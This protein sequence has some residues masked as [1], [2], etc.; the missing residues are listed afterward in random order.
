MSYLQA[1]S[2]PHISIA[3]AMPFSTFGAPNIQLPFLPAL[4]HSKG[5][6]FLPGE[7]LPAGFVPT[8]HPDGHV[9]P[10]K[11]H[12]MSEKARETLGFEPDF[13]MSPVNSEKGEKSAKGGNGKKSKNS[14]RE[15]S[16][17]CC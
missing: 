8:A 17:L 3:G 2:Q 9:T 6:W 13:G 12:A 5:Q 11:E 16:S 4:D 15:N 14:K 10:L 1:M 7:D